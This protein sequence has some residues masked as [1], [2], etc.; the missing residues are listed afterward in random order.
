MM[1]SKNSVDLEESIPILSFKT[2]QHVYA[3]F[4]HL[5]SI[6]WNSKFNFPTPFYSYKV[7]VHLFLNSFGG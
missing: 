5:Q 6:F 2:F 7:G 4:L 1:Y 3:H